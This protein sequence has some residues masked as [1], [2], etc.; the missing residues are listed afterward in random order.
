[1]KRAG[2]K[3]IEEQHQLVRV[4]RGHK[5][6]YIYRERERDYIDVYFFNDTSLENVC[7]EKPCK[8][9]HVVQN[10]LRS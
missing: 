4:I 8:G 9:G 2:E 1:M 3:N 5:Y 7:F 10:M 6:I